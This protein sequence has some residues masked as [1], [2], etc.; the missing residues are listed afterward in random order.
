MRLLKVDFNDKK[1]EYF[2]DC[3]GNP[4]TFDQKSK[5][6]L[7][8]LEFVSKTF[9][10]HENTLAYLFKENG[11]IGA[12]SNNG[13][14]YADFIYDRFEGI[15]QRTYGYIGENMR[16]EMWE[17]ERRNINGE[18]VY[19]IYHRYELI[20]EDVLT[21]SHLQRDS[22]FHHD[23]DFRYAVM[24]T[25]DGY[26][27]YDIFETKFLHFTSD[28]GIHEIHSKYQ[29]VLT[30][31]ITSV[32]NYKYFY[33]LM[34]FNGNKI[35]SYKS[36]YSI[37]FTEKENFFISHKDGKDGL[38]I[39]N[40]GEF[41][42]VI[43]CKYR[44]ILQ[45][46]DKKAV[47]INSQNCVKIVHFEKKMKKGVEVWNN[48][49]DSYKLPKEVVSAFFLEDESEAILTLNSGMK[50]LLSLFQ[51]GNFPQ[52]Q[53]ED[54]F[55]EGNEIFKCFQFGNEEQAN[56]TFM[57]C[58]QS[59][60]INSKDNNG[61]IVDLE[62]SLSGSDLVAFTPE[63]KRID[64]SNKKYRYNCDF[65]NRYAEGA[66]QVDFMTIPK[67]EACNMKQFSRQSYYN[68]C[69][70]ANMIKGNVYDYRYS[71]IMP[72]HNLFVSDT[73]ASW[74][75]NFHIV[76]G[77]DTKEICEVGEFIAGFNDFMIGKIGMRDAYYIFDRKFN[78]IKMEKAKVKVDEVYQLCVVANNDEAYVLSNNGLEHF[79]YTGRNCMMPYGTEKIYS[80]VS[81][82][83]Y[84]VGL[85]YVE[86]NLLK[87]EASQGIID[88]NLLRL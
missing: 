78:P 81:S 6:N 19:D 51:K 61:H 62:N 42:E 18:K 70:I 88:A 52:Y 84:V 86:E 60:Q 47:V 15:T 33:K 46:F 39:L 53:C 82:K 8:H 27:V 40:N 35:A 11:K 64:I 25:E 69:V 65:G 71:E 58:G 67:D 26:K 56:I 24:I 59:I 22:Y 37:R 68:D 72:W 2:G 28:D 44:K 10:S 43:P 13:E 32:G 48:K 85:Q 20:C 16:Q 34:D 21:S 55:Y 45:I 87:Y 3:F 49:L 77:E 30:S 63:G 79:T 74:H 75:H 17:G 5:L 73:S 12:I 76:R 7:N 23:R 38:I 14:V 31:R 66:N 50:I 83:N 36:D 29:R 4:L 9:D 57:Y 41:E 1:P 54:I 80:S